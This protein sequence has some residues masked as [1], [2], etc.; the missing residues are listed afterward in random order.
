MKNIKNY[1]TEKYKNNEIYTFVEDGIYLFKNT[2]DS[3][4]E[5]M[6]VY[7]NMQTSNVEPDYYV[8]SLSFEQ[9]P[10][11]GE[12]KSSQ[13]ISQYPLEDILDRFYVHISDFYKKNNEESTSL[14]YLEFASE[15]IESIKKLRSIIN[16]QVYNKEENACIALI[17]E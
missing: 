1:S 7:G 8:T 5:G 2:Y 16:K 10:F 12:G 11:L 9:E 6:Y 3:I 15:D 4:K 14:C 17:I 13:E